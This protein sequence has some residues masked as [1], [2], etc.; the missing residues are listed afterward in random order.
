MQASLLVVDS[1]A[2][3]RVALKVTLSAAWYDVT[4][5]ASGKD[6][7]DK[8]DD[9]LP[10]LILINCNLTDMSL[11]TFC[12]LAKK[13]FGKKTPPILAMTRKSDQREPL[14]RCGVEDVLQTP[15]DDTFLSARI[16]SVLRANASVAEWRL[17]DGTSRALGFAEPVRTFERPISA[18]CLY[19]DLGAVVPFMDTLSVQNGITAKACHVGQAMR[20]LSTTVAASV[21]ILTL[22]EKDPEN[23]LS[24]LSDLRANPLSRHCAILVAVPEGRSDLAVRAL[25][26]GADDSTVGYVPGS[27]LTLRLRR[28]NTR[29]QINE[30]LRATVK[31]GAEA[32]LRDQL[33]GLYNRRYALPHLERIA[34][35]S[36]ASG[37]PF[38]VMVADLDHF[39]QVNDWYGHDAGDAVL[40]ECA[41][42]LQKNMRAVDMLARIG[43]EEFL[44]VMPN[45]SRSEAQIAALR[46]CNRISESAI[47]IDRSKRPIDVTVSIG[48]A[49]NETLDLHTHRDGSALSPQALIARADKALY[50]AKQKGRNRFI[51]DHPAAA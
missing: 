31:N 6:A 43:G 26:L 21:V 50:Q 48:L 49:V 2:N 32:A 11:A 19:T 35:Q 41:S 45:T 37:Q 39:K 34:E 46:L 25:D 24:V 23:M 51:L 10:N 36:I 42:R 33:T 44:V 27:E 40:V 14:L 9:L 3:N 30:S 5:A 8:I 17:R 22:P 13:R 20:D 18:M 47:V 12:A 4:V 38:A 29:C 15:V 16:R 28:L 1:I 7:L